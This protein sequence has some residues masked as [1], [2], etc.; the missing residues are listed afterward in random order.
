MHSGPDSSRTFKNILVKYFNIIETQTGSNQ[1]YSRHDISGVHDSVHASGSRMA[2]DYLC[3]NWCNI[4]HCHWHGICRS[5]HVERTEENVLR[6]DLVR[7]CLRALHAEHA[8]KAQDLHDDST[9]HLV[10]GNHPTSYWI[11]WR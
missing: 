8:Q 4:R 9:V 1:C 5:T 11:R 6:I 2:F 7:L 10:E 3:I